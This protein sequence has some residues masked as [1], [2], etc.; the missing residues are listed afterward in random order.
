MGACKTY[1]NPGTRLAPTQGRSWAGIAQAEPTPRGSGQVADKT[2]TGHSCSLPS[3]S[4]LLPR[5]RSRHSMGTQD[6]GRGE[7]GGRR[8]LNRGTRK[9]QGPSQCPGVQGTVGEGRAQAGQLTQHE[10]THEGPWS[11]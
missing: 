2:E 7:S 6:E 3:C 10:R 11:G 1:N 4:E 8:D 9:E 5:G